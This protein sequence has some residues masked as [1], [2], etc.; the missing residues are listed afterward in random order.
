MNQPRT[1]TQQQEFGT[2]SCLHDS[3]PNSPQ[4][5]AEQRPGVVQAGVNSMPSCT[6]PTRPKPASRHQMAPSPAPRSLPV[7]PPR[8]QHERPCGP[9]PCCPPSLLLSAYVAMTTSEL[10]EQMESVARQLRIFSWAMKIGCNAYVHASV[11]VCEPIPVPERFEDEPIPVPERFNDELFSVPERFKG[12]PV[13]ERFKIEPVP[14][15]FKIDPLPVPEWFEVELCP[16]PVPALLL[17]FLWGFLLEAQSEK[18][19]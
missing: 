19:Q 15:R 16:D 17:G 6:A 11:P 3:S 14:E 10:E 18:M 7:P 12:E 13:P 2:G 4:S 8:L 9:A 5:R 1:G